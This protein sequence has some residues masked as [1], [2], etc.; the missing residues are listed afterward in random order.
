MR[1]ILFPIK[2]GL[3]YSWG[4]GQ[5]SSLDEIAK[6]LTQELFY[7]LK[8]ESN[9]IIATSKAKPAAVIFII[10]QRNQNG[11]EFILIQTY[12]GGYDLTKLEEVGLRILEKKAG[13]KFLIFDR[14]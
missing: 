10:T 9:T 13:I 3:V 12:Q 2:H 5:A 1:K 4:F 6:N 8:P 7:V 14:T 11:G